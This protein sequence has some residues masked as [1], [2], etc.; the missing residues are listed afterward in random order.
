MHS[1]LVWVFRLLLLGVGGSLAGLLGMAIAQFF[2]AQ[3]QEPPL[4]EIILRRSSAL[5]GGIRQPDRDSEVNSARPELPPLAQSPAALTPTT[6]PTSTA[7]ASPSP[8]V[9]LS[10]TERENLQAELTALQ[11]ELTSL[12]DRAA[13][14]EGQIGSTTPNATTLEA[15]LQTLEQ[16]ID[17]NAIP[18]EDL[19]SGAPDTAGAS[20]AAGAPDAAG[21]SGAIAF[22]SPAATPISV[23]PLTTASTLSQSDTLMV[24]LPSDALFGTNQTGLRPQ[25]QAI[26]D[27]I[28]TDLQRYEGAS[29]RIAAHTDRQIPAA[30]ARTISFEQAKAVEQYLSTLLG[31]D[32]HW[33]VIGYGS[34]RPLVSGDSATSNERNRRVEITIDPS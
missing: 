23:A 22:P 17:P 14:L 27:S 11:A 20:D 3:T 6:S 1:L 30:R 31:D 4:L 9:N 5:M 13:E 12:G 34:N 26:L 15:R 28:A 2:P 19:A 24:T 21:A 25:T 7:T 33:L 32:Y 8:T 29:I 10:E 18:S 16:Q